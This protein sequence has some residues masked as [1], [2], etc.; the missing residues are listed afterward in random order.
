MKPKDYILDSTIHQE[1]QHSKRCSIVVLRVFN[2][3]SFICKFSFGGFSKCLY[4]HF[5]VCFI[6]IQVCSDISTPCMVCLIMCHWRPTR[7]HS[8]RFLFLKE[9]YYILL[10]VFPSRSFPTAYCYSYLHVLLYLSYFC[11]ERGSSLFVEVKVGLI[12]KL[13]DSD[14]I[15]FDIL[16]ACFRF[17]QVF[18]WFLVSTVD[19]LLLTIACL[20]E[21]ILRCLDYPT[22]EDL[23]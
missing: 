5:Q 18:Y 9:K 19:F 20:T 15:L 21:C 2:T 7:F 16:P 14:R 13:R 23:P 1:C 4:T 8:I 11:M 22:V 12:L 6:G 10:R 3:I 17:W